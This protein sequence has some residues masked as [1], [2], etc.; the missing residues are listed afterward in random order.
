MAA[1]SMP[2]S[3]RAYLT[4]LLWQLA[5]SLAVYFGLR[6]FGVAA[7]IAILAAVVFG[8]AQAVADVARGKAVDGFVV[9]GFVFFGAVAIL[10]LLTK[11]PRYGQLASL[12]PGVVGALALLV[13]ALIG[14]P[15]TQA[16]TANYNPGLALGELPGRGWGPEDVVRYTAMHRKSSL[17]CGLLLAAQMGLFV[18]VLR[19]CSVDVTQLVFDVLGGGFSFLIVV[20]AV[21]QVRHFIKTTDVAPAS[22]PGREATAAA[23]HSPAW[24]NSTGPRVL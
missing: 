7:Y 11:N 1:S 6:A 20:Y 15:L 8:I 24:D 22:G 5:P 17:V 18:F 14:K 21:R 2:D 4:Q 10:I 12:V 13:S 9:V 16:V 23:R 3:L 19:T